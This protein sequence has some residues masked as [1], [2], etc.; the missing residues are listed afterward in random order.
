MMRLL[1]NVFINIKIIVTINVNVVGFIIVTVISVLIVIFT[2]AI[3]R[4]FLSSGP[5]ANLQWTFS[6]IEVFNIIT[7]R[8]NKK[9]KCE[10]SI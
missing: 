1:F 9:E 2:V 3:G 5:L 8:K 7:A 6:K 10:R 4:R